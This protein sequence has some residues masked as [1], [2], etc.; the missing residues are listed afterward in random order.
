MGEQELSNEIKIISEESTD[1]IDSNIKLY[2][3]NPKSITDGSRADISK[4]KEPVWDYY[5]KKDNPVKGRQQAF[6]LINKI[7]TILGFKLLDEKYRPKEKSSY[8]EKSWIASKEQRITN[9]N[10][11]TEFLKS[12]G[13]WDSL[14]PFEQ[15]TILAKVWGSVKA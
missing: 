6:D 11:L 4:L 14:S 1:L 7:H 13:V 15:G 8:G 10:D 9:C 3:L 5:N 2:E 12:M